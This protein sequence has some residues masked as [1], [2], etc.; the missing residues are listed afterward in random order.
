VAPSGT[1]S[2][3]SSSSRAIAFRTMASRDPFEHWSD[4]APAFF[5]FDS[6]IVQAIF[7]SYFTN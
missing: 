7:A 2:W 1:V 5:S 4:Y 6:A 3:I